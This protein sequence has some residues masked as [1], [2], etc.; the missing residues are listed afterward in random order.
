MVQ[1]NDDK[2]QSSSLFAFTEILSPSKAWSHL[3]LLR[4]TERDRRNVSQLAHSKV[5]QIFSSVWSPRGCLWVQKQ[6]R[7]PLQ[8]HPIQTEQG[9]GDRGGE[10]KRGRG[11]GEGQTK[12]D[13]QGQERT[14]SSSHSCR[15][16]SHA[17]S[18]RMF[19]SPSLSVNWQGPMA[20]KKTNYIV[21]MISCRVDCVCVCVVGKRLVDMVHTHTLRH[22]GW[23]VERCQGK[24]PEADG[25]G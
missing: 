23:V 17:E 16:S 13:R 6:K 20:D 9:G 2:N 4:E 12:R 19:L 24:S 14:R 25:E 7:G 10:R 22:R 21:L 15:G 18:S 3:L 11:G 8:I 1:E 5:N